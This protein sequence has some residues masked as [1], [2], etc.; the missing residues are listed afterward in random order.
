[1]VSN[2]SNVPKWFQMI[3]NYPPLS[4]RFTSIFHFVQR[5][6]SFGSSI[7]RQKIE[8]IDAG[9]SLMLI[10]ECLLFLLLLLIF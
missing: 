2:Y 5:T 4:L 3:E 1:M 9:H 6:M 8:D 10:R 7:C